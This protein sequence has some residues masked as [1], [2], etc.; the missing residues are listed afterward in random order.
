[1]LLGFGASALFEREQAARNRAVLGWGLAITAFFIVLRLV[2]G[3]GDPNRWESHAR[4]AATVIDF[5]NTTKYPPSL[6]FLAMTLGPA[7]ILCAFADRMHGF[8]KDAGDVRARA[9]HLLR[10]AFLPAA[11]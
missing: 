10:A 2:D 1:M 11:R 8:L 6:L 5:L 3:Y 9:V 4:T 7:A